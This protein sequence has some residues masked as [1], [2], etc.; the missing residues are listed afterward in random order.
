MLPEYLIDTNI[1]IYITKQKPPEVIRKFKK[2]QVGAV[3]M[4]VVNYGELYY[5][6]QKSAHAKKAHAALESL[7]GVIPVLPLPQDA[8]KQYGRIRSYLESK[9]KII[10]NND[11]W[12][13]AHCLTLNITLVTNNVK[14]FKRVPKLR[15]ENWV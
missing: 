3:A 1:C 12:I 14:E 2:L 8:A 5:G 11:L 10:G 6:S 9:G 15:I 4:S 7:I 13:A